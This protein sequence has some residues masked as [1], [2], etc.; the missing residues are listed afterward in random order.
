MIKLALLNKYLRLM[1]MKI[2]V[3]N[4]TAFWVSLSLFHSSPINLDR[5][6]SDNTVHDKI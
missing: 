6:G 1:R 4:L 3:G 5:S 2:L